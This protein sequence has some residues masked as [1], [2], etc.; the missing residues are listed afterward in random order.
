MA[1]IDAGTEIFNKQY[2]MDGL[3]S[4][5]KYSRAIGRPLSVIIFDLDF[6]KKV[7]DTYGH[8]AGDYVLKETARVAKGVVRKDDILGRFGGEEFVV[9]LPNSDARIATEL[10]DRIRQVIEQFPFNIEVDG[11]NGKQK[12]QHRQTAS[13]G[14]A[15]L[16]SD[17]PGP[18]A[19]LEAADKKLYLSKQ[20]G[21][22]RVTV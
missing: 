19:L 9:I 2:L 6:F 21:R 13:M 12:I 4:E 8:N 22:N 20:G 16:T 7:N 15:Q 14:V 3:E 17:M 1:T 5:I 11:P 18:A 10:A